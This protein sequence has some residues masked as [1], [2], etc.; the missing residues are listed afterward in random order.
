MAT[1]A[2]TNV[3]PGNIILAADILGIINAL[4]GTAA[5]DIRLKAT[6]KSQITANQNDYAIGDGAVFL[7]SSDASRN[8]TGIAGGAEGRVIIIFNQGA[9]NIVFQ[10][11]N[12]GS[13]AAN[14]IITGTGAD[15]T[16]AADGQI[17]LVYESTNSR[18]RRIA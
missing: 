17:M 4:D 2:K 18:W 16:V 8:V 1:I 7:M 11:Q 6:V 12:A 5:T 10:N 15:I 14:R 9:Q 13:S 3:V